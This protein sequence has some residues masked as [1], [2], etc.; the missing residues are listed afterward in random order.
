MSSIS[1]HKMT[2]GLAANVIPYDDYT[3]ECNHDANNMLVLNLESSS[4][5]SL[6]NSVYKPPQ[7]HLGL[8]P[9]PAKDS[10]YKIAYADT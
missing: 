10:S 2:T 8:H 1:I 4:A 3:G 9:S 7:M 5:Q 6:V